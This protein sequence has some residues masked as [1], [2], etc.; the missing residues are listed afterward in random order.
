MV[1]IYMRTLK[2]GLPKHHTST[3]ITTHQ[4]TSVSNHSRVSDTAKHFSHSYMYTA[5]IC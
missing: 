4:C 2:Q 5:V 1:T 3:S